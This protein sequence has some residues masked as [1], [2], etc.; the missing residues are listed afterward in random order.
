MTWS[1][2]A[3]LRAFRERL[4][5]NDR[6]GE[7]IRW[8]CYLNL[9]RYHRVLGML[10][11][12]ATCLYALTA[13]RDNGLWG[14]RRRQFLRKLCQMSQFSIAARARVSGYCLSPRGKMVGLVPAVHAT[15]RCAWGDRP[16]IPF[17]IGFRPAGDLSGE[18]R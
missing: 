16:K 10:S 17:A 8:A 9:I 12:L 14:P 4:L 5:R 7:T 18:L 15:C 6:A 11:E 1:K 13:T 2:S 3:W